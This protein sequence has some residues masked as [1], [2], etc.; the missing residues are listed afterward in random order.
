MIDVTILNLEALKDLQSMTECA[1]Q[2]AEINEDIEK[3]KKMSNR[4]QEIKAE[5]KR[6]EKQ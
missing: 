6:R 2:R 3:Y 4:L 5:L 1:L